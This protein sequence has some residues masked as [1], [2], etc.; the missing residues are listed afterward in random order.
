MDNNYPYLIR[1]LSNNLHV[2]FMNYLYSKKDVIV[3]IDT[4]VY[5][6]YVRIKN[7]NDFYEILEK[8]RR[9]YG[10]N[11]ATINP[12]PPVQPVFINNSII[13]VVP[14]IPEVVPVVPVVPVVVP[15]V[16]DVVPEVVHEVA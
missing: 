15:V 3:N 4:N 1:T 9:Y 8:T 10:N 11:V 12:D 13:P 5:N 16:P 14:V 7:E 6:I 2:E